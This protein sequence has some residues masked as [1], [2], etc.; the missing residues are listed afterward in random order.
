MTRKS[1]TADNDW[2]KSI[3]PIYKD[4]G[5]GGNMLWVYWRPQPGPGRSVVHEY[6]LVDV[7]D[8]DGPEYGKPVLRLVS[9]KVEFL[10]PSPFVQGP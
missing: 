6:L 4:Q 5:D 3:E 7:P 9:G 10:N 2:W 1:A 8:G